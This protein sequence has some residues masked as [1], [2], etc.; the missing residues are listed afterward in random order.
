MEWKLLKNLWPIYIL[1]CVKFAFDMYVIQLKYFHSNKKE[2]H[3]RFSIDI[4]LN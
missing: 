3:M 2:N 4:S 1:G